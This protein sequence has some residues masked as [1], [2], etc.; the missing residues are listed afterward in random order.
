[1]ILDEKMKILKRVALLPILFL[2]AFASLSYALKSNSIVAT[3]TIIEKLVINLISPVN[4]AYYYKLKVPL[5][6]TINEP[7]SWIG[8]SLDSTKNK[9]IKGNTT[10][11]GLKDGAH[12]IIVYANDSY[13]NNASTNK[14]SF[15]YCLAD[16]NGDK[17]V[18]WSDLILIS[19]HMGQ[20]C[21]SKNYDPA[22]DLNDDCSINIF[23]MFIVLSNFRKTCKI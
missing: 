15:S 12:N 16:I 5:N 20:K 11:N 14:V 21:K 18:N 17:K 22:Y 6:F 4:G 13:G 7:V 19:K 9:T 2:L 3:V 8:Y 10:L 1:M 23:D